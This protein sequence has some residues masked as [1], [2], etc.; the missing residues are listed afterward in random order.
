VLG[1]ADE[2]DRHPHPTVRKDPE[3]T[4]VKQARARINISPFSLLHSTRWPKLRAR[5]PSSKGGAFV[6]SLAA[7]AQAR[8]ETTDKAHTTIKLG[9]TFYL[10]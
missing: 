4:T 10:F 8:R 1:T 7:T 9:E 6:V 3:S 5:D 2:E